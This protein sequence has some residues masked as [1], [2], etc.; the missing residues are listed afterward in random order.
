M[1]L[2]V[3]LSVFPCLIGIK[4]RCGDLAGKDVYA[5]TRSKITLEL[6]APEDSTEN[7]SR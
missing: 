5:D 1:P 4:A 6:E 2:S 7:A 3:H